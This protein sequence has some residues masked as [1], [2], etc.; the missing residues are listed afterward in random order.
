MIYLL[1]TLMCIVTI[2]WLSVFIYFPIKYKKKVWQTSYALWLSTLA[3][4]MNVLN[5]VIQL[6]NR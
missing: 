4:I 6:L 2:I 3:L 1:M 5:I